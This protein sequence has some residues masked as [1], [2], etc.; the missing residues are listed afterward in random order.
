M[1]IRINDF[2]DMIKSHM[3]TQPYKITCMDCGKELNHSTDY[4]DDYDLH[5]CVEPCECTKGEE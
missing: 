5:I 3:N 4:D 1:T 2:E